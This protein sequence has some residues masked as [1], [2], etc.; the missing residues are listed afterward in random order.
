MDDDPAALR[1][2]LQEL[3]AGS[4]VVVSTGGVSAGDSDW[5]RPL[6]DELGQVAFWKLFL[7]PGRP[8]AFGSLQ[9][10]QRPSHP[11]LWFAWQSRGRSDH[12]LA[13]AVASPA[14]AGGS[15]APAAAPFS[16]AL[17][18]GPAPPRW[19]AGVSPG[20]FARGWFWPPMAWLEGSQ[21]SS[22]IGSLQEADLLLELPAEATSWRRERWCGRNCCGCR[23]L[24]Q[25]GVL[26]SIQRRLPE[27]LISCFQNGASCLMASSSAWQ[28]RWA[29]PRRSAL[30]ATSTRA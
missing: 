3:A 18:P 7:K 24:N 14:T 9:G 17:G 23:F 19:P 29:G 28:Q 30:T 12:S 8:F 4:D 16:A 27:R 26:P 6:L 2:A 21:A 13:I 15:Q 10:L 5:I 1:L 22:R 20:S 11:L 25:S